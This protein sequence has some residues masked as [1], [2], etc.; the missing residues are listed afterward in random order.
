MM[1]FNTTARVRCARNGSFN[2]VAFQTL[3]T[4]IVFARDAPF[5]SRFSVIW[6]AGT[7][8]SIE[9]EPIYHNRRAYK[10]VPSVKLVAPLFHCAYLSFVIL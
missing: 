5:I 3:K 2:Y 6:S 1:S 8:V 7:R 9:Y 4:F 10:T